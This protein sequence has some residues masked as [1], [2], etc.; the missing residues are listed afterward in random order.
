MVPDRKAD[1]VFLVQGTLEIRS[2]FQLKT[3]FQ[4]L[5]DTE[6]AQGPF[7]IRAVKAEQGEAGTG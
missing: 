7:R 6:T 1:F 3:D 5:S 2:D 4:R